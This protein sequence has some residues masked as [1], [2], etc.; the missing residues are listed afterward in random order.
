MTYNR[1][2]KHKEI[3]KIK[4]NNHHNSRPGYTRQKQVRR[5]ADNLESRR[6][7]R[8]GLNK[9]AVREATSNNLYYYR[10]KLIMRT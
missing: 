1:H 2:T 10:L 8:F 3:Q 4:N 6:L 5:K 7:T 9:K